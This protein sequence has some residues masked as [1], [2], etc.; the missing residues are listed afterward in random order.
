MLLL[1]LT[2]EEKKQAWKE[3]AECSREPLAGR[4]T[5]A[6]RQVW[7]SPDDHQ[8]PMGQY[9]WRVGSPVTRADRSLLRL[10][11]QPQRWIPLSQTRPVYSRGSD[12]RSLWLLLP[13]TGSFVA[14]IQ[15]VLPSQPTHQAHLAFRPWPAR[16]PR[17][18][19]LN[20]PSICQGRAH[21]GSS[22]SRLRYG[23]S[24]HGTAF[25]INRV[26]GWPKCARLLPKSYQP[27]YPSWL[28]RLSQ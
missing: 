9:G 11:S 4:S 26:T 7:A 3:V 1:C 13:I 18:S 2:F 15:L 22:L 5:L 8:G 10:I 19:T 20:C 24:C 21:A 23:I 12:S 14:C 28:W 17:L 16:M 6:A 27:H 25:V